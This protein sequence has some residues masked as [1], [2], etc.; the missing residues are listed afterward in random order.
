M[1]APA[2][3]LDALAW[4]LEHAIDVAHAEYVGENAK[5]PA[6]ISRLLGTTAWDDGCIP[7]LALQDVL[8]L[9]GRHGPVTE[10]KPNPFNAGDFINDLRHDCGAT[11]YLDSDNL[12]RIQVGRPTDGSCD[13]VTATN[14]W[15]ALTDPERDTVRHFIE[16]ADAKRAAE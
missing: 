12:V 5:D 10:A 14:R 1:L 2:P 8:R 4:K 15:G 3:S 16:R 11:I 13:L 7:A 6:T 9:A